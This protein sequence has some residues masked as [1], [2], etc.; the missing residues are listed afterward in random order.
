MITVL[1]G[2]FSR[3]HKGHKQMIEAAFNTGNK[4]IVGLST[5]E[6]L[7]HNKAY[8]GYTYSRRKK[9]LDRYMSKFG[10]EYEIL[11]LDTS[12]GNTTTNPSYSAIVVSR[13]TLHVAESINRKRVENKLE[14]LEIISVPIVLA[15]DLFPLSS[16][17][18]MNGEIRASGAR[19]TPVR[20]GIATQNNLKQSTAYDF[21]GGIMKN[22]SVEQE[23][24]YKLESDQPFGDDTTGFATRRAMEAL[25]DRDYGVGIES[26]VRRDPV[27]G[28]Y[29]EYH[30][31]I[32]IDRYSRVTMGTSSGFELPEDIVSL[33][34]SGMNESAAFHALYGKDDIGKKGGVIGEFSSGMLLRSELIRESLRNAFIP[35]LGAE[36]FGLDHKK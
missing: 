20:I 13:E 3:L 22:Y 31:C 11:P 6:Y 4:V 17:R 18:I 19:V 14:P 7:R 15:E 33:M 35:R 2:S 26:G 34:K 8:E 10:K 29:V 23:K 36:Y 1:G 12:S 16:S 5:D 27:N 25:K 30:V 21:F 32:V 28:K 9:A 24:D